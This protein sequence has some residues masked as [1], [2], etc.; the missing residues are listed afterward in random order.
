MTVARA[1]ISPRR[2]EASPR[3]ERF[4]EGDDVEA[5]F[6][7]GK[8]WY[9]ARVRSAHSD[10]TYDLDYADGDREAR[11]EARYIKR[12]P[13]GGGGGERERADGR[14]RDDAA[15]AAESGAWREGDRC[16]GRFRGGERWHPARVAAVHR[17]GTLDLKYGG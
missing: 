8:Q 16:E 10:N 9:R 15:A 3:G 17:D 1:V 5:R 2:P 6:Q 7:R 4:R 11:V 12:A 13:G 14:R